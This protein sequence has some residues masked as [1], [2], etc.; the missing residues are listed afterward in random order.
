MMQ[1]VKLDSSSW[2]NFIGTLLILLSV[3]SFLTSSIF[4]DDPVDKITM[5]V[6]ENPTRIA[7][8]LT[9][10]PASP[11]TETSHPVKTYLFIRNEITAG[12]M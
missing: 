9:M 1:Y 11:E 7:I 3:S 12:K 4:A 6:I 10:L 2:C 5:H 8:I